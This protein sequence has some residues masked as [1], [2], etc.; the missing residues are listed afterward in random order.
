M[1][2]VSCAVVIFDT[3]HK[4]SASNQRLQNKFPKRKSNTVKPF[5]LPP[6]DLSV[7]VH[8][9]EIEND[10]PGR[11]RNIRPKSHSSPADSMQSLFHPVVPVFIR[12][13]YGRQRTH[14]FEYKGNH[15]SINFQ[16]SVTIVFMIQTSFP[17]DIMTRNWSFLLLTYNSQYISHLLWKSQLLPCYDCGTAKELKLLRGISRLNKT[18][19]KFVSRSRQLVYAYKKPCEWKR[20]RKIVPVVALIRLWHGERVETVAWNFSTY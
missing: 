19:I 14:I 17:R 10:G 6:C 1:I 11:R 20:K 2:P 7:P 13:A 5:Q 4:L 16:Q 12:L 8:P 18:S 3:W 15:F 9:V